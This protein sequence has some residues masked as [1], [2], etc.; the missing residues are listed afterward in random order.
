MKLPRP[1]DITKS[2]GKVLVMEVEQ[3]SDHGYI[4]KNVF[5][6]DLFK[7]MIELNDSFVPDSVNI[8][9]NIKKREVKVIDG[10]LHNQLKS[11]FQF[12]IEKIINY[13]IARFGPTLSWRDYPNWLT[14]WHQDAKVVQNILMVYLDNPAEI[15]MGTSYEE[16]GTIYTAPYRKNQGILLLNTDVIPHGTLLPVPDYVIRRSFYTNWLTKERLDELGDAANLPGT[17]TVFPHPNER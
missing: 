9:D 4:I 8:L 12:E 15:E 16:N 3:L 13:S 6:P 11:F 10:P 17:L 5:P 1:W 14:P 2:K 7:E